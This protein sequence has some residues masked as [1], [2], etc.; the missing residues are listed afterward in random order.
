MYIFIYTFLFSLSTLSLAVLNFVIH[1][2]VFGVST[3]ILNAVQPSQQPILLIRCRA[4]SWTVDCFLGCWWWEYI[5]RKDK[6]KRRKKNSEQRNKRLRSC[7]V[8]LLRLYSAAT[9]Y[10]PGPVRSFPPHHPNMG[11]GNGEEEAFWIYCWNCWRRIMATESSSSTLLS[12]S[13]SL[14]SFLTSQSFAEEQW[15]NK[16]AAHMKRIS[17]P[18]PMN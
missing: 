7:W 12:L 15:E 4:T 8:M 14:K 10:N 9:S 1:A 13:L 3:G 2:F 17:P 6:K 18:F 5:Y 16:R 11:N